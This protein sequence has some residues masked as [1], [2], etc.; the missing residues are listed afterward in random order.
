M[1]MQECSRLILGLR[2]AGWTDTQINDLI[3]WIETGDAAY[4]PKDTPTPPPQ[5]D[6]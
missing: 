6:K 3:L 4:K 2:A 5:N 1:N